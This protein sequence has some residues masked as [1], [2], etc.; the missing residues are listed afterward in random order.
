VLANCWKYRVDGEVGRFEFSTHRVLQQGEMIYNTAQEVFPALTGKEWYKTSGFKELALVYGTTEQSYRKT[1]RHLN[2]IRYQLNGGTPSRTVC[3]Q[4]EAEG[5]KLMQ[6]IERKACQILQAHEF[7]EDGLFEGSP[8][9]SPGQHPAPMPEDRVAEA[10]AVCQERIKVVCNLSENPVSYEVP[11]DTVNIS[12]DDVGVKRQ[13]AQREI[14][15]DREPES[16]SEST[17]ESMSES[18]LMSESKPKKRKYVHNTVI[19]IE[20]DARSYIVNGHGI[21][22]VLS[23]LIAFLVNSDLLQ[24]R[25]Q[26]FTDG[27]TILHDAILRCFSWYQNLAIILDWY[28]LEEKCKIQL[29]LAMKGRRIRNEVL[30]HLLPLLWY[31]LVDHAINY[32]ETLE[33]SLLKN[34]D[35]IKRL[36]GYFERNRPYIPCYA[37][38]KELGLRNS[39]NIGEKMNDL[40]VSDRQKHNGMSWSVLGSVA[41]ASLTALVRNNEYALWFEEGD[42]EFKLAA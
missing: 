9:R 5:T 4:T 1:S 25:L 33:N 31:G 7:S 16:T 38:R 35:A 21:K 41:L 40:V 3:E 8:E 37:V 18:E 10:I 26:F 17:S 32:L 24:Y 39:S 36:I 42:I 12:I 30:S 29:S 14:R 27:Y 34:P 2:R 15:E 6:A 28:H 11:E 20:K 23:L 19:H 22:H 13:K